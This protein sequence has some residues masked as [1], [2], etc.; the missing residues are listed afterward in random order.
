MAKKAN[1][2]T[3]FLLVSRS[4]FDENDGS[5][6]EHTSISD[7]NYQ[8]DAVI[9]DEISRSFNSITNSLEDLVIKIPKSVGEKEH[10]QNL[11][12]QITN[13]GR[14]I[15]KRYMSCASDSATIKG[16]L[17]HNQEQEVLE[18]DHLT[19]LSTSIA[20]VY[21]N[22]T[23]CNA[24]GFQETGSVSERLVDGLSEVED[25][26]TLRTRQELRKLQSLLTNLDST[27]A[28]SIVTDA[29][30]RFA[31]YLKATRVR[32]VKASRE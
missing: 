28:E 29:E 21:R 16:G 32:S 13:M 7:S 8:L 24:I 4:V 31:A 19:R 25:F 30:E 20:A 5:V 18:D 17:V 6:G 23:S 2:R 3:Y 10:G 12:F 14:S 1:I 15:S 9:S 27:I 11:I 26:Q 22:L